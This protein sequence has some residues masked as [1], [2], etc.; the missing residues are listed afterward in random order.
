MK[1]KIFALLTALVINMTMIT[2]SK[3]E[4]TSP[5]TKGGII[6]GRIVDATNG[7]PMEYVSVALFRATD[8]SL[9]TGVISKT[10][11]KF[12][13]DKIAHGDYYLK[14][15]FLGFE[16]LQSGNIVISSKS[17]QNEMGDIKLKA[18]HTELA[19]VSVVGER[20]KVEYKIDKKVINV[21]QDIIARGGTAATVL[22]NTPSVQVDAEGNLTLRGSSE[23]IVLIDGKPSVLKG[24]DALKQVNAATI[25]QIE[26]ITNPSAR[27]EAD[28]KAGIINII[29]KKDKMQG[30]NGTSSLSIATRDKYSANALV[31]YRKKKVNLFTGFDFTRNKYKSY[32]GSESI[33][34]LENG[35]E[36]LNENVERFQHNDNTGAKAGMDFDMNEK[37]SISIG[38]NYAKKSYQRGSTAKYNIYNEGST[39]KTWNLG[40]NNINA[41][42]DVVGANLDYTHKFGENHTLSLSNNYASWDGM[43]KQQITKFASNNIYEQ[44]SVQSGTGYSKANSNCTYR[45]NA[46]YKRMIK[47]GTLEAGFQYRFENRKEDFIYRSYNT[48]TNEWIEDASKSY[49]LDYN[50]DIYSGYATY[51]DTKW[52]I[53]YMFG[54]R[55]EYFTRSV[56]FSNDPETYNFDKFMLY[57]SVHLTKK[58]NDKHQFQFSYSRRINRPQPR[59]LNKTPE[60]VDPYNVFMGNPNLEPEFTDAYEL[61]YNL[62]FK[63]MSVSLLT[64]YRNTTNSFSNNRVLQP[65]G[66]LVHEIINA[67]NQRSYGAE[68]GFNFKLTKKWQLNT[69]TNLYHYSMEANLSSGQTS[70]SNN[71]IDTRIMTSYS[72]KQGTKVQATAYVRSSEVDFQGKSQGFYTVNLAANQPVMKGKI[73]LGISAENIFNSIHY[74][75][76]ASGP[77]YINNYDISVEGMVVRFTASYSFNN[78]KNKQRGRADDASFKGG[79]AF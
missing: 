7:Q 32:L 64:Y 49:K 3:A 62:A 74:T 75:Y 38:G 17:M 39:L 76:K 28:G 1:N 9:V 18:N 50:N 34:Y 15:T 43:D 37:N 10:D 40:D 30:I 59:I 26:V 36:Y 51:S 20:S 70:R 61:N 2:V 31:N 48:E 53:G 5:D 54:L 72:F 79:G 27:Y 67:D 45:F 16:N 69:N 24:N 14:I 12:I 21:D 23:F 57:P 22:E 44:Q 29:Q 6:K 77:N 46:D 47:T 11:G 58:I 25:K 63:K 35:T 65:D 4:N 78:F 42:G 52:G 13:L 60:Y 73:N 56:T 66:V 71:L 33:S 55:T 41:D 68:I 8:S 19:G